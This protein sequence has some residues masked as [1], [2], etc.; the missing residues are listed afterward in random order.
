MNTNQRKI[1]E[2]LAEKKISVNEAERL[3]SLV[4]PESGISGGA[5]NR[6]TPKYLRVVIQPVGDNL[7]PSECENV[8]IR[9]PM[10][11]LRAGIKLAA[12]I[13]P[14]AY[15][16]V[17]SALKSKGIQIDLRDIKPEHVEELITA[18]SELEVNIEDAKNRVQIYAE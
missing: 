1:L 10:A 15:N 3:M 18:L 9:V 7:D 14:S 13:P 5:T 11:L 16:D 4:Q 8:N 17:D 2:M 6:K 12:I